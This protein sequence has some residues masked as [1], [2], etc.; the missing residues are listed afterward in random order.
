[1]KIGINLLLWTD[2]P[3]KK[4][5]PLLE[6][7]KKWGFDG[8]E[9]PVISMEKDD[10]TELAKRCDGLGLDRSAILAF[11]AD[12]ADPV[13]PDPKL[14]QAAVDLLK[15]SID[16]TRD[17]GADVLVGPIQQ[18]L[19]R[20]TGAGPSEDEWKRA[21]E[22]IRQAAAHAATMHVD[23]AVEPLN[24]FEMF[25]FNTIDKGSEFC[26]DVN[27]PNVGILAD[28]HHSNIEERHT[29]RAWSRASKQIFHV[30]ISENHRGVPGQGRAVTPD[31]FRALRTSGYDRWLTIE[32]FGL[33]V[34]SLITPLHLWRPLFE[35]VEDVPVLGL[36][37][38]QDGWNAAA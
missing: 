29:G 13:N 30:H 2:H 33:D 18:G 25:L 5:G 24:R 10:I 11:G 38:I 19:G 8:V 6:K 16:K 28:T 22:V 34:P 35:R 4:H 3:T 15:S 9:F 32:A 21:A 12:Q 23:L 17:I 31:V 20:F 14:R 27:M 37:H 1:M 26:R 7:I 36:K